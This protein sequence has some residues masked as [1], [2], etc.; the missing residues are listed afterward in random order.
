MYSSARAFSV[1][2]RACCAA[3]MVCFLPLQEALAGGFEIEQA[4]SV[5]FQGMSMAGVAAGGS[6]ISSIFWNPAAGAFAEKGLTLESSYSLILS[7]AD[8]T[9]LS[10]NGASPTPET[11]DADISR[12]ALTAASFATW[13]VNEKTVLGLSITSPWGLGSKPDNPDWVGKPLTA[14]NKLLTV[15]VTP[16]LS[17]EMVPGLAVGAGVQLEYVDLLKLRAATPLGMSNQ[18]GESLG[19]GFSAGA[20]FQLA[21]G[22][23][24]GLG[25]RSVIRH[26]VEGEVELAGLAKAAATADIEHPEKVTLSLRQ[27]LTPTTRLFGTVEWTNWSRLG[28]IPVVLQAPF[29]PLGAGDTVAIHDY[30]WRDGWFF[31]LGG[32]YDWSPDLTLRAGAAYETSPVD[33]PTTRPAQVPDSNRWYASI[34]ASYKCSESISVNFSYH[35]VF[36]ENDVA[37]DRVPAALIVPPDRFLGTADVS[38]DVVGIGIKMRLDVP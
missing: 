4:Q 29:G 32:E 24:I 31:A 38:A 14:T 6:S 17:Y 37:F 1:C 35:H 13:R 33:E 16:S 11:A 3:P 5:Y 9:V 27:T 26:E 22:T 2:S 8:L 36:Y 7:E 28:V 25:F 23:S 18:T 30:Q 21:T 19:I 12:D 15:N 34:G 20:N 10:V